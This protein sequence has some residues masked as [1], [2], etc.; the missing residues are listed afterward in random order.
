MIDI[1]PI[2]AFDGPFRFLSNF[3]PCVVI[4][5]GINYPT[6][7]HAYQAAKSLD[8]HDRNHIAALP[9]PGLAKR[10]G[11]RIE[12]RKD[13][14]DVK[15]SVM[16]KILRTK[17]NSSWKAT[18]EQRTLAKK[19]RETGSRTLVEGNTWGDTFWGVCNGKGE[20]HLG[21]LLMNVRHSLIEESAA[22]FEARACVDRRPRPIDVKAFTYNPKMNEKEFREWACGLV[23]VSLPGALHGPDEEDATLEQTQRAKRVDEVLATRPCENFTDKVL[24][25]AFEHE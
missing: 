25:A 7:E 21:R 22:L 24:N 12:I 18:D 11:R 14:E 16:E 13:W 4:F 23:L 9:T 17:F 10:A 6:T 5:E 19:L 2:L 1:S 20:N 15:L 8:W 3:H